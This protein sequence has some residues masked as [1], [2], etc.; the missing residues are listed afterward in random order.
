[1]LFFFVFVFFFFFSFFF[2]FFFFFVFVFFFSFFFFFFA[3]FFFSFS[4]FSFFF[5]FFF[6]FR[7]SCSS[8]RRRGSLWLNQNYP[9]KLGKLNI[10]PKLFIDQNHRTNPGTALLV[11]LSLFCFQ[12]S[13]TEQGLHPGLLVSC[14]GH[15]S[16]RVTL[17]LDNQFS[18]ALVPNQ[19]ARPSAYL[20]GSVSKSS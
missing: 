8:G 17:I 2:F 13:S 16:R 4:F 15:T 6:F 12:H 19:D 11:F 7:R 18:S 3:F 1:M 5:F 9:R 20:T 14:L 10:C